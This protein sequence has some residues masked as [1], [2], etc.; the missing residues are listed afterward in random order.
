MLCQIV[1]VEADYDHCKTF[2]QTYINLGC[3]PPYSA[4]CQNFAIAVFWWRQVAAWRN[5]E[6]DANPVRYDTTYLNRRPTVSGTYGFIA[7]TD[8]IH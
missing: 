7:L 4:V 2:C 6:G 8:N 3:V 1:K 5:H